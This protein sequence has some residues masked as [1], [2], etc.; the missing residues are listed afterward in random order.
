MQTPLGSLSQSNYG[1]ALTLITL[2]LAVFVLLS[3]ILI[4]RRMHNLWRPFAI[5][6]FLLVVVWIVGYG[7]MDANWKDTDG[8]IDCTN[9][10]GWHALGAFLFTGPIVI[11]VVLIVGVSVAALVGRATRQ[12]R[13]R[14]GT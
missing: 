11:G 8:W 5:A 2:G 3:V 9:C 14:S 12:P 4:G 7:L 13:P 1:T 6:S 10:N